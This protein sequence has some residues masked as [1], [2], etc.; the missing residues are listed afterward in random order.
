M[1]IIGLHQRWIYTKFDSRTS[2][3]LIYVNYLTENLQSNPKLFVGDTSLF[4][5]I[6]DPNATAKQLFEDIDKIMEWRFQWEMSSNPDRSKQVQEVI[7]TRKVKKVVHPPIFFHNKPIQP[8][9]SKQSH[10]KLVKP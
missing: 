6:N 2:A 7:F 4:T 1:F 9:L 8:V 5:I 10:L 3:F